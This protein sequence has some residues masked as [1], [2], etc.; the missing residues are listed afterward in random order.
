MYDP[1]TDQSRDFILF[2]KTHH[3]KQQQQLITA[4]SLSRRMKLIY[5][6]RQSN[7]RGSARQKFRDQQEASRSPAKLFNL[8]N[9]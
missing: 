1:D 9:K 8:E 4:R 5:L 6:Q 7:M 3:H 2:S